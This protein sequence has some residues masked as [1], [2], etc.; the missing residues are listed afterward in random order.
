MDIKYAF[1]NEEL[2]EEVYVH[3]PPGSSSPG[4]R[5]RYCAS[6]RRS[7]DFA[8][9]LAHGMPSWMRCSL[10][11]GSVIARQSTSSTLTKR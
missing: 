11:L 1:L 10:R 5:A 6:T 7:I 3:Q 4:R 9:H 2:I 8:K